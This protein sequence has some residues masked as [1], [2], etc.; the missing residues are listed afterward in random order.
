MARTWVAEIGLVAAGL[1]ALLLGGLVHALEGGVL[2]D[3]ARLR[4]GGLVGE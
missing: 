1:V 3:I 2:L 4:H